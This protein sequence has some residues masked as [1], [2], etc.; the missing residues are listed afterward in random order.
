M[1]ASIASC[2][3]AMDT[4]LDQVELTC[5]VSFA[6]DGV[7]DGVEGGGVRRG[8]LSIC[9][10]L[11]SCQPIRAALLIFAPRDSSLVTYTKH[12]VPA[13]ISHAIVI[14]FVRV[15]LQPLNRFSFGFLT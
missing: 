14:F 5:E 15:R 4:M 12:T 8:L 9:R 1:G 3:Q 7:I 13:C 11:K 6:L 2:S 10:A